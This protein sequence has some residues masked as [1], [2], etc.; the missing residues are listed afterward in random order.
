MRIATNF[1]KWWE[2]H[3]QLH[4]KV[5]PIKGSKKWAE[6]ICSVSYQDRFSQK[7]T[8]RV[9]CLHS[10]SKYAGN[11]YN[12]DPFIVLWVKFVALSAIVRPLHTIMLIAYH[13][14]GIESIRILIKSRNQQE[15]TSKIALKI[16]RSYADTFRVLYYE[17]ILIGTAAVASVG[18]IFKHTFLYDCRAYTDFIQRK[19]MR[20]VRSGWSGSP[21][22]YRI[23]NLTFFERYIQEPIQHI[24]YPSL[25]PVTVGL[26]NLVRKP[27]D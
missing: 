13:A 1:D 10:K 12:D 4:E 6:L 26:M 15:A 16:L 18:G 3:P 20:D 17:S 24:K 5:R 27:S 19:L 21:C 14:L 9:V 7:E 25:D 2:D 23:A 8:R 22:M 11:I